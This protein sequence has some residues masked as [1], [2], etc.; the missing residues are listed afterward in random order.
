MRS[1]KPRKIKN[2]KV[3]IVKLEECTK[4]MGI[5][6]LFCFYVFCIFLLLVNM[7]PFMVSISIKQRRM[8]LLTGY[9]LKLIH[10]D[11]LVSMLSSRLYSAQLISN[12]IFIL[13]TFSTICYFISDTFVL[14][15]PVAPM[16]DVVGSNHQIRFNWKLNPQ[17]FLFK[18]L[19][20]SCQI[21]RVFT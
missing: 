12:L 18:L 3:T 15:M 10:K 8:I 14:N 17:F 1:Q 7:C 16:Y 11:I 13:V 4:N 9:I 20:Q 21:E 5:Q 2:R 19:S 6:I